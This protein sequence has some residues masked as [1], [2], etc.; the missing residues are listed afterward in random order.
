MLYY[1]III[2][3]LGLCIGSFLNCLIWRLHKKKKITGRSICTKCTQQI[4][5]FD[6]IPVVSFIIL[7]GK[8]RNCNKSISWQYPLLE[9]ITGILFV[10]AFTVEIENW[11][12]DVYSL[13]SNFKFQIALFRDFFLIS[14]MIVIFV[15]DLRW[16]L[17]LDRVSLP[18]C[19]IV[20][21]LN[22]V[23][24]YEW[25]N[26][27]LSGIIGGGFF[28]FQFVISKGKWIGG[29]D[30]RL[31]LLMGFALGWPNILIALFL[32]YIS[33]SVIGIGLIFFKKKQLSSK[34][35]FG[36]FFIDCNCCYIV[37]G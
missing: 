32:A 11:G 29:G 12:L 27:F 4:A 26:L 6:N 1:L 37:L 2:F 16:Y 25:Q 35:P 13:I 18:A 15:Y 5:W 3:I 28:L 33:G 8:C 24:G 23:L 14:I 22:L 20:F 31:G 9:L 21:I 10:I 36:V 34:I 7:R 30:I 19:I 17:I